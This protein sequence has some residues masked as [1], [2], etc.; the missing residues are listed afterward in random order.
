VLRELSTAHEREFPFAHLIHGET[1]D[2]CPDGHS[3]VI[4]GADNGGPAIFQVSITTGGA[5]RLP[6][7]PA[8]QG[9]ALCVA[10]NDLLYVAP[11]QVGQ[12]IQ[13]VRRHTADGTE[14]IAY[15]SIVY[16]DFRPWLQLYRSPDGSRIAILTQPFGFPWGIIRRNGSKLVVM[17]AAGGE[18]LEVPGTW[19]AIHGIMWL[20]NGRELL[21]AR[22]SEGEPAEGTSPEITFW[23]VPIN[24][25]SAVESGRMRV[26]AM[27]AQWGSEYYSLHP[28]GSRIVFEAMGDGPGTQLWAID[29]MLAFIKSG[30]TV[31]PLATRRF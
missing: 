6:V 22:E 30:K 14:R 26:P 18:P 3:V 5:E 29:N 24:G 13:L 11:H 4:A 8:S 25:G 19:T 21:V 10:N 27:D 17:S 15:T 16:Q 12:P 23:R 1:L 31:T 28:S 2:F 9:P 20:P 7:K